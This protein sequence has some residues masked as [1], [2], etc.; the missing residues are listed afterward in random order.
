MNSKIKEQLDIC[1]KEL[2]IPRLHVGEEWERHIR[3][4]PPESVGQDESQAERAC[5]PE[6]SA[7]TAGF[8]GQ[9]K[10][11]YARLAELLRDCEH[12]EPN[13]RSEPMAVPSHKD[14]H[15]EALEESK[16]ENTK[17]AHVGSPRR[18]GL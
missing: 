1:E 10:G 2:Q 9:D 4:S 13:R 17:P 7:E 11:I 6:E 12:E 5:V 14:V 15:M 8:S 16:D 3:P 18:N